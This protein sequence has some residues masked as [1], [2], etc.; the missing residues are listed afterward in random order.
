MAGN[1]EL[2]TAWKSAF[3][4]Q[5]KTE[6]RTVS[7]IGTVEQDDGW[8]YRFFKDNEGEYWFDI[9][10]RKGGEVITLE[11]SVFGKKR[12]NTPIAGIT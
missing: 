1:P 11:E 8:I 12:G 7:N 4:I 3:S 2:E 9:W 5:S 10:I 6:D